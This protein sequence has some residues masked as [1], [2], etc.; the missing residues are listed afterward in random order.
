MRRIEFKRR[1][2]AIF[3]LAITILHFALTSIAWHYISDQI[4]PSL[5]RIVADKLIE[6]NESRGVPGKNADRIYKDMKEE[7]EKIISKWKIPM[8]LISLP[9]RPIIQP[10]I[11][12]TDKVWLY[13]PGISKKISKEQLRRRGV[14]IE[15][16]A[17]GLNSLAF[18]VL[19][20]FACLFVLKQRKKR[21]AEYQST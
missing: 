6:A 21:Q 15:Y 19:I 3:V 16:I 13:E 5:G 12:E 7:R 2:C 1:I 14:I 10:L 17:N 4:G 9:L 20:Y 11:N 18:G 8:M